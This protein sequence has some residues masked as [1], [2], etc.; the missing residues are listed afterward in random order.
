MYFIILFFIFTRSINNITMVQNIKILANPPNAVV[1]S[2]L[3]FILKDTGY[4]NKS[5]PYNNFYIFFGII[6]FKNIINN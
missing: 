5:I 6:Y 1:Y 3:F 4:P 2:A